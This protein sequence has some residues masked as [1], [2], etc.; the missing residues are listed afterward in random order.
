MKKH[1]GIYIITGSLLISTMLQAQRDVFSVGPRVGVN[2]ANVSNVT[3]SKTKLG[4]VAG[5]TSTYSIAENSGI[6]VDLL[7]S[8]EGYKTP[9][10]VEVQMDYL[11][12][13]IYYNFF[14]GRLGQP[15]R[16]KVYVGAA[17]GFLLSAKSGTEDIKDMSANI[18]FSLSGGL[19]LNY[20]I[21]DKVWLNADVRS[22]IGLTDVRD[23]MFRAG[24]KIAARNVQ[25]SAGVAFGLSRM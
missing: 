14:L 11:Q 6:T 7:Y 3:D 25:L 9:N 18:A 10:D 12:I 21:A 15:L 19:G 4:L 2:L 22:F 16:P 13:P 1:I 8:S 20:R 24:D 5:L 17:P 23:K